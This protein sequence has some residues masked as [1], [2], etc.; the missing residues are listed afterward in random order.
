MTIQATISVD[1][2]S[3]AEARRIVE[4]AGFKVVRVTAPKAPPVTARTEG[5]RADAVID[6]PA[7]LNHL[8]RQAYVRGYAKGC[9]AWVKKHGSP[10]I[11]RKPGEAVDVAALRDR[12]IDHEWDRHPSAHKAG[13]AELKRWQ[14]KYPRAAAEDVAA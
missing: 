13:M 8:E 3:P 11:R 4:A 7:G 14:D 9:M 5:V 2:A 10:A 1:A 12:T 6:R